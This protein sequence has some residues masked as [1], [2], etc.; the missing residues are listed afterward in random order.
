MIVNCPSCSSRYAMPNLGPGQMRITCQVCGHA[1]REIEALDV[2][3]IKPQ[4]LARIIDHGDEPHTEARRLSEIA[5]EAQLRH[6]TAQAAKQ[7][8]LKRWG[9]FALFLLAPVAAAA[10]FPE[11]VV[12]AAPVTF[13][14]YEKLGFEVNLY[15]LEIRKVERQHAIVNG[16]RV[17]S[18]KGDISNVSAGVKKIP[19]LRFALVGPSGEELYSWTLDTASRPLS[20]GQVTSF[21]TRV[22]APPEAA[23]NL[24]IRFAKATEIGSTA[25][26]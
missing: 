23:Q 15:G 16:T 3:E 2:V 21:V 13:R 10:A 1:W 26:Q 19:W 12:K 25:A 4:S 20:P 5:R 24:Q 18:I 6:A 8:G 17:L 22:A 9:Y 11:Q 7:Q 14:A